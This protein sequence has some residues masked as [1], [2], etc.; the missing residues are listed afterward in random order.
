MLFINGA[1][2]NADGSIEDN[3]DQPG[4]AIG[5]GIG[6]GLVVNRQLHLGIG[7]T[8]GELGH[9]VIDFN[10]PRCGCGN[11]GCLE[12]YASG[13]A[14]SA[15]G[16][17]AVAQGLTTRLGEMCE[18]DLNSSQKPRIKVTRSQQIFMRRQVFILALR[19]PIYVLQ[20][21]RVASSSLGECRRSVNYCSN[22]SAAHCANVSPSC[23]LIRWKSSHRNSET[24]RASSVWLAGQRIGCEARR[25]CVKIM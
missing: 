17:K 6:G 2:V 8:G 15:M 14:I 24:T 10:G 23:P 21:D 1:A 9:M 11:Y 7:R 4:F 16:M 19:R 20:L 18:Y 5:T 3:P 25:A 12:A 13:P 22:L